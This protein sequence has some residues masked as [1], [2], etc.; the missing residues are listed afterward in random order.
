EQLQIKAA[1]RGELGS[2]AIETT[3]SRQRWIPGGLASDSPR[4]TAEPMEL[5]EV[6][7]SR[8]FRVQRRGWGVAAGL[9]L[10][11]ALTL[12]GTR[13]LRR[14]PASLP[15]AAPLI[16]QA[17]KTVMFEV[18]ALPAGAEILLDG[19]L[20]GTDHF[21]GPQPAVNR[22][23]SLEVRAS[24]HLPER[25]ELVLT[26]DM[27]LQ[28]VL[29]P[30]P[31]AASASL[32]GALDSSA[33]NPRLRVP[34]TARATNKPAGGSGNRAAKCNPPY[35]FAADGVKTYKPECF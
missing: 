10:L 26:R 28:I 33:A 12:V 19:K 21:S 15:A 35:V 20:L 4:V 13:A 22:K 27:S 14:A 2:G 3:G 32:P 17:P 7:S 34:G 31:A 29:A 18:Q 23:V 25:K 11:V 5:Q 30:D 1:L 9:A 8:T 6:Q 24:G 16:Q